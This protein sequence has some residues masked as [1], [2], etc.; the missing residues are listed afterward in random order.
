MSTRVGV[1]ERVDLREAV[2]A[3]A[4]IAIPAAAEAAVVML[5]EKDA[6]GHPLVAAAAVLRTE[7]PVELLDD[8]NQRISMITIPEAEN[9]LPSM[10]L[11]PAIWDMVMARLT[12]VTE[13]RHQTWATEMPRP[14]AKHPSQLELVVSAAAASRR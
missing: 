13:M 11:T 12:W 9:H 14:T 5:V 6:P 8:Q 7:A 4:A 1:G 10:H 2:A 3:T